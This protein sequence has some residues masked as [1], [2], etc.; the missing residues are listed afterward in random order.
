MSL[1]PKLDEINKKLMI[2]GKEKLAL[3]GRQR[4]LLKQTKTGGNFF[5]DAFNKVRNEFVNPD[6]KLRETVVKPVENIV[7]KTKNEF[8]NPD[9]K[10]RKEI[11]PR[12]DITKTDL[13]NYPNS[14][15]KTMETLGNLPV[16]SAEIVRTPI[17]KVLSKFI[18]LLSA[19]K[20]EQASKDAGYDKLFHLQLVLNVID[21]NGNRKKVAIQKTERVQVDG[22]LTGVTAETEYL[23]ISIGNKKFTPNEMLE[24]TRKRIGDRDFF[25]YD[26]FKNNCQNFILNLL[27]SEGLAGTKETKFLYQDTKAI[28]DKIPSLSKKIMNFTTDAGNVFSKVLGFGRAYGYG[29]DDDEITHLVNHLTDEQIKK[30][31]FDAKKELD[32]WIHDKQQQMKKE[33]V[34]INDILKQYNSSDLE[35]VD[36]L[37]HKIENKLELPFKKGYDVK[38]KDL[39]LNTARSKKEKILLII[40]LLLNINKK[41]QTT[42]L[43]SKIRDLGDELGVNLNASS[44]GI[45]AN[46]IK[47]PDFNVEVGDFESFI[48]SE[49][50]KPIVIA[51]GKPK[52]GRPKKD[53]VSMP[54]KEYLKEHKRLIKV[55]DDAGKE[56]QR[57]KQEVEHRRIGGMV[58][59]LMEMDRQH[60]MGGNKSTERI[61]KK[62]AK[63]IAD[64][65]TAYNKKYGGN[66]FTD[67][68]NTVKNAVVS[69]ANKVGN[70]FTNPDSVFRQ[71]VVKPVEDV[72]KKIGNEFTNPSSIFR[73]QVLAPVE[74]SFEK[75]GRDTKEAFEDI[76]NKIKNE[77]TNSDSE[78]ARAFRPLTDTIGNEDWW[79]KTMTTPDTYILLITIALDVA[80]MA[81]VPGAGIASAATKL[82]GDL[83]QGRKVSV[84]DLA[85]L[86]LAIIPTPK[87]PGSQ[88]IFNQIKSQVIGNAGMSAVARSQLI[89]RNIVKV[90]KELVGDQKVGFGEL[91]ENGKNY[92]LHA[93]VINKKNF[94]KNDAVLEAVKY[95][96]KKGM[97]MRETKQSFRFRNI[98]KTKFIPKSYRTKKIGK[99]GVSLI[100]GEL[101]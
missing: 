51:L 82:I 64:E 54:K 23:N 3:K 44:S 83:A 55:L 78:L 34:P 79:K 66:W 39:V 75:F 26:S 42:N 28:A 22:S 65:I 81:G 92:K 15:K 30:Y 6:S 40:R 7:N 14:A 18:N 90:G 33:G 5:T 86:A 98:P 25:G 69:T 57:Q 45:M 47:I 21:N 84:A 35:E 31:K 70:E 96:S 16:E 27:K 73:S 46:L 59:Q 41:K 49:H 74:R 85:N 99:T 38:V 89:G 4:R 91:N 77:F 67:A 61:I 37:I 24:K 13:S 19:G 95:G 50:Q 80:A 43:T 76:G 12:F 71:K 29:Y 11:V 101:K 100:Y 62:H 48:P 58:L 36:E 63:M 2:I 60:K 56:G 97:F 10:L 1:D 87:V 17:S 93:I 9:S 8:E 94:D 53:V 72:A 88:G 52:R 20:F 68:F 32:E